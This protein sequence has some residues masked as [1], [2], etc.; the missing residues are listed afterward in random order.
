MHVF[1]TKLKDNGLIT[2]EKYK[3]L[4]RPYG[5]SADEKWG[6]INRQ[7]VETSQ[8]TKALADIIKDI[9]P[10]VDIVYS[11]ARL[12]SEFR[13][14][15]G[16]LKSRTYN[17]LHHAKDAYLNI[18]VGNVY[19]LKFTKQWFVKHA[20]DK[21]SIKTKTLFTHPAYAAGQ[22]IWSGTEDLELVKNTVKKNYAHV[23]KYAYVRKGGF[24]DQMPLRAA[25]GLV[26]RKKGLDTN[27]YGGYGHSSISFFILVKYYTGKKSDVMV[28]PVELLYAEVFRKDPAFAEEYAKKQVSKIINKPVEK[29]EF[30]LGMR[31]LKINTVFSLDGY[32]VT[33]AG[34]GGKGR[35]II[36]CPFMMFSAEYEVEQ[37]M[38]HLDAFAEKRNRNPK[39]IYD[40]GH[41]AVSYEKN[42]ALY[43]L[44][45]AKLR[46]SIFAKR[47]NNPIR[48]L[49]EGYSTFQQRSIN[50][51]VLILL[52]I[53]NTFSRISG[54]YDLELI[55]GRKH[56]GATN[57]FSSTLSNWK[58]NY[59]DVRIIDQSTTGLWEKGRRN[60]RYYRMAK[61]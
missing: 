51:Q 56:A 7:I 23:T 39:L 58:K 31:I 25:D 50:E 54:G 21:Y 1:W 28:M 55:G 18:V 8:S 53:H 40:A 16:L 45:I 10:E 13:H 26:P 35:C 4:T 59:S 60:L 44:Y 12:A 9:Y 3:R 38:K 20:D 37:Y 42:M 48:V 6:F 19:N 22:Q 41:D 2:E 57:S 14:E 5:F 46:N 52:S 33:L 49:E 36:A 30:P 24:F 43:E 29:V 61:R 11:K 47:I 27:R 15:F 34:S 32:R 17:D